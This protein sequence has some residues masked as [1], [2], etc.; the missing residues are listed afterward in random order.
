MADIIKSYNPR[1]QQQKVLESSPISL[2]FLLCVSN[3]Q[4]SNK[5]LVEDLYWA[6]RIYVILSVS[7]IGFSMPYRQGPLPPLIFSKFL[8][9]S[10][11]VVKR[12]FVPLPQRAMD[13]LFFFFTCYIYYLFFFFFFEKP[14]LEKGGITCISLSARSHFTFTCQHTY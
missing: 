9:S 6:G 3:L 13:Q 2:E 14:P 5:N 1:P 4:V 8:S 10:T 7:I 11:N 12:L